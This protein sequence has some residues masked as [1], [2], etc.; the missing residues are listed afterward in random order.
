M[1]DINLRPLFTF[2]MANNHMG[3]VE[4]GLRII[5]EIHKVIGQ[6]DFNFGFKFQYRHLDTFIH[7]DFKER[8]DI[9][10]VKRFSET[11]LDDTQF[12]V[13]KDE[14]DNLGFVSVCTPFDESSVD[15]I[16]QHKF[17]F[18]KIASCSFTDWPLL[19]R[20]AESGKP[21]IASAAGASLNNIDK[22][23]S[24]FEHRE[25][26]ITLMHCVAE[27]PTP[28]GNLQLDQIDLLK[29]RYSQIGIGY[30]THENPDN[31]DAIKIAIAKGATVFERHVGIKTEQ[32]DLNAYSSIPEQIYRWLESA[33][34][35]FVMCGIAGKRPK[36][37]EKELSALS[38]LRRGVFASRQISK[39]ERIELSDV[40]LAIPTAEDQITANDLSKYTEFYAEADIDAREPILLS[41]TRRIETREKV[42]SI[43]QRVKKILQKGRVVA[44]GQANFEISHHYG[45]DRFDEFGLTMITV[46]NREYCKKL[47]ILLP[48]QKNPEHSHKLKEET[49][50]IL[51]GDVTIDLDEAEREYKTGEIIVVKRGMKHSFGSKTGAIIEEISS[52]HYSGDSYYTDTKV[53][54]NKHRKTLLTYWMN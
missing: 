54:N 42:Y 2:D 6:F 37:T 4:H 45:V 34:E 11:K 1:K 47:L 35:A 24:F 50:H 7:P 19:E 32:F 41:K 9:K 28:N 40:F 26:S 48:G 3:S 38:A 25:N 10:Y 51:Y 39:G 31:C 15:L 13:L 29:S 27:Y 5:R 43:V 52:T 18:I 49:F 33:Q 53:T 14:I 36:F 12:K 22:V 21:V 8:T 46:V 30:S 17:D 23:V 16:E 20:I 44:P